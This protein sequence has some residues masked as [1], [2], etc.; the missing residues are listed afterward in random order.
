VK[1]DSQLMALSEEPKK[2]E[3]FPASFQKISKLV[4][5]KL[6]AAY[7]GFSLLLITENGTECSIYTF[8]VH[9]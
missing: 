6:K 3:L 9:S 5:Q 1:A 2:R 8:D 4:L 7:L